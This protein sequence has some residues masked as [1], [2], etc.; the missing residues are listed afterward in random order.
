MRNRSLSNA[1][2]FC[3][4]KSKLGREICILLKLYLVETKCSVLKTITIIG[5]TCM[6]K[7]SQIQTMIKQLLANYRFFKKLHQISHIHKNGNFWS[8]IGISYTKCFYP[9]NFMAA[10]WEEYFNFASCELLNV[11]IMT[12]IGD[13]NQSGF[14]LKSRHVHTVRWMIIRWVWV[15]RIYWHCFLGFFDSHYLVHN[16]SCPFQNRVFWTLS[17]NKILLAKYL[18]FVSDIFNI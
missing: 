10:A 9:T 8:I 11:C 16:N 6:Q 5:V 2:W 3:A 12:D 15:Y 18:V 1:I 13:N 17:A 14:C 4:K 7:N